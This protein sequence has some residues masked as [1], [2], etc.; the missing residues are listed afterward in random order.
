MKALVE[1]IKKK[2]KP[3]IHQLGPNLFGAFFWLMKLVVALKMLGDASETGKIGP[4]SKIVETTSGTMGYGIALAARIK[5]YRVTLVGDPAIDPNLFN[6]L[7]LLGAKV[8]IIKEKRAIGGYQEPR[9]ER[10]R[11]IVKQ[12]P[13]AFW[14]QQY[15]NPSNPAAY[16]I[17]ASIIAG[18]VGQVDNLVATVGS[19]GSISGTVK[20]LR[21][22]GHPTRAIAVDTFNSVLFGQEDGPRVLRGLGN[23]IRPN[24]LDYGLIDEVH[25]VAAPDAFCAARELFIKYGH[26]MGP[27]TGAAF[28]VAKHIASLNPNKSVV[29]IGPDRAERYLSTVYNLQWCKDNGL[30]IDRSAEAPIEVKHPGEANGPWNFVDWN[31]RDITE[32]VPPNTFTDYS[33]SSGGSK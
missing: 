10:V 9:L 8:E 33:T 21:A 16:S 6:L 18:E 19:G 3:V 23:S 2:A 20:E 26:D 27:T 5:K 24:N 22:A 14:V 1:S 7:D 29:F 17:P 28:M 31:R 13:N 32:I 4:E 30:L 11:D 12:D 25:W 15:H